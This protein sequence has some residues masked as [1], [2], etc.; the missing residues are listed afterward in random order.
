VTVGD[1]WPLAELALAPPR[2]HGSALCT[3]LLKASPRDFLVEE[4]LPFVPDGGPGHRLLLVEKEGFDTLAVARRLAHLADISPRD[5]GF[6]G[7]K[8]RRACARQWFSLPAAQARGAESWREDDAGRGSWHVCE[9][10]AHGR[11]L[12]RGALSGNRFR[13]RLRE[14][15]PLPTATDL[16]ARLAQV[17]SR[18]VP[19][20]FGP[21]R[22]G[23]ELANL[24]RV[25]AFA[26]EGALPGGRE[27]RAFVYSAARSLLFNAVLA[28]RVRQGSWEQLLP[29]ERVNL[30]GSRSHFGLAK[31]DDALLAR[32]AALDVHPTGPLPGRGP[33]PLAECLA[34][35]STVLARFAPLPA[36]LEA[37]GL[38]AARRPLRLVARELEARFARDEAELSFVLPAGAYATTL[39]GEFCTLRVSDTEWPVE[40]G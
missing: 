39:L 4:L 8:D 22:F 7:L 5:V 35:E 24:A 16:A 1:D 26:A 9:A 15:A 31:A 33:G 30:D 28:E 19:N 38:A 2:A 12:K 6:A 32:L 10:H 25:R 36:A 27:P 29:G 11:K 18:G 23:R 34:L 21:Q 17:R 37:A 13:I 40:E 20:Y 3:A 14:L